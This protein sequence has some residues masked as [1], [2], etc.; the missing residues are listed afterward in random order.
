MAHELRINPAWLFQQEKKKAAVY[1]SA[2]TEDQSNEQLKELRRLA[3]LRKYHIISLYSDIS[4]LERLQFQ[5]LLMDCKEKEFQF[6]ITPSIGNFFQSDIKKAIEIYRYLT[7]C[8]IILISMR[9]EVYSAPGVVQAVLYPL[10]A[11]EESVLAAEAD[12]E[13]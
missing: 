2:A 12:A 8:G 5:K 4:S 10:L 11:M 13:R 1:I 3:D 6:C 7:Q 9:E